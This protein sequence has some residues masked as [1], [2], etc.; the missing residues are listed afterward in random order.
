MVENPAD[1]QPYPAEQDIVR[2]LDNPIKSTAICVFCMATSQPRVRWQNYRQR[3]HGLHRYREMFDSEEDSLKAILNGDIVAGDVVVIRYEGP[4]GPGMREMLSPTGAIMGGL[5]DS[6]ALIT[7]GRFSGARTVVIGHITPEA[8]TG[9][10]TA[11][12]KT[13]IR[14]P[15]TRSIIQSMSTYPTKKSQSA[16]KAGDDQGAAEERHAGKI[17]Q[18]RRS[19]SQARLPRRS[20]TTN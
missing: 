15:S 20:S 3:R 10:T 6:V 7:D 4:V 5:G 14:S 17:R 19:A 18:A 16:K 12:C 2:A 1:V 9:G 8:A 11:H 13:V